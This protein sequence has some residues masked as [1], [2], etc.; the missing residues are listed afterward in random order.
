[1]GWRAAIL[2]PSRDLPERQSPAALV[3]AG[4]D[5]PEITGLAQMKREMIGE[6]TEK[7]T[8]G[9]SRAAEDVRIL[10]HE[11]LVGEVGQ[12]GADHFRRSRQVGLQERSRNVVGAEFE[13]A[14]ADVARTPQ[15]GAHVILEVPADVQGQG[16]RRVGDAGGGGP[17]QGLVLEEI[18]LPG[19][20]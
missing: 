1:M 18:E 15:D 13:V 19:K 2:P 4:Q 11:A 3:R 10:C 8:R 9:H 14:V 6:L 12:D 7:E 5:S 17:D 16:A 20:G